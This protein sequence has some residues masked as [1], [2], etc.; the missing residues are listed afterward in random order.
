MAKEGV[1]YTPHTLS[2]RIHT[3]GFCFCERLAEESSTVVLHWLWH[4]LDPVQSFAVNMSR[5]LT[6]HDLTSDKYKQIEIINAIGRYTLLPGDLYHEGE[7][8]TLFKY[9]Q[10]PA[11]ESEKL[12]T[13]PWKNP[14]ATL[15]Y[16][17]NKQAAE[18]LAR[19]FP[20]AAYRSHLSLLYAYCEKEA[21]EEENLV[22]LYLHEKKADIM[23][24]AKGKLTYLNSFASKESGDTAYY[25][26]SVWKMLNMS[27]EDTPLLLAGDE[28]EIGKM[29]EGIKDFVTNLRPANLPRSFNDIPSSRGRRMPFDLQLLLCES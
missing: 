11:P 21:K 22:T 13:E 3:D 4:P 1:V 6:E 20:Q 29:L 16:S 17:L 19:Q 7:E 28:T 14:G 18:L 23:A 26:L 9:N 27:Q 10:R 12:F 15:I 24:F 5:F 8:S 2:I 25:L